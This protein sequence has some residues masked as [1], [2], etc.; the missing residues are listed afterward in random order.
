MHGYLCI[1]P[2][3]YDGALIGCAV[4]SFLVPNDTIDQNNS[5]IL[6]ALTSRNMA[7]TAVLSGLAGFVHM[8]CK[9]M[10]SMPALTLAFNI[11]CLSFIYTLTN[12]KSRLGQLNWQPGTD[13][14]ILSDFEGNS[15]TEESFAFFYESSIRGVGQFMFISTT[16]GGWMVVLGIA[17]QSR[18]S[19]LASVLGA[20]VACISARY[21]FVVPPASLVT[22]HQGIYGYSA[23]GTC[24][25]IGGG[26]FYYGTAP[27]LVLGMLGAMFSVFNQLAVEAL[28]KTDHMPLPSLTIP[29][30]MTTWLIMLT[31]SVWL[32]PRAEE[33]EDMDDVLFKERKERP[34][35]HKLGH[36]DT[37]LG[38]D[39]KAL[40]RKESFSRAIASPVR[41]ISRKISKSTLITSKGFSVTNFRTTSAQA[42]GT[43]YS[44][45]NAADDSKEEVLVD[46]IQVMRV[47]LEEDPVKI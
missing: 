25:A 5:Y 22:V 20:F 14:S 46:D 47:I 2:F 33:G 40:R 31:R 32:E 42:S 21:V 34:K 4:F 11:T 15:Y 19:A 28:L 27:A 10:N 26:V 24:C 17:I 9:N 23:A 44:P 35:H 38:R 29:F 8:A 3:R 6:I 39:E 45:E 12:D 37:W 41:Q 13:D 1:F 16:L 43:E 18:L 30:V 36:S 7:I